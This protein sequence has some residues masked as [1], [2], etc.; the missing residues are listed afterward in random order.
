MRG[1]F[2]FTTALRPLN[3][4]DGGRS[5]LSCQKGVGNGL[6][7]GVGCTNI[8]TNSTHRRTE[9]H[10]PIFRESGPRNDASNRNLIGIEMMPRSAILRP[11]LMGK[12]KTTQKHFFLI[13]DIYDVNIY[14]MRGVHIFLLGFVAFL[15]LET[16]MRLTRSSFSRGC[17]EWQQYVQRRCIKKLAQIYADAEESRHYSRTFLDTLFNVYMF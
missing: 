16:A 6:L 13:H 12:K 11:A 14:S 8:K 7:T 17:C 2:L 15:W 5:R 9:N 1:Y 10:A 4:V 3:T